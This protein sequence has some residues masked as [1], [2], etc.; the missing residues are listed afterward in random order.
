MPCA[1]PTPR[2][3]PLVAV[4]YPTHRSVPPFPLPA[5][6][7]TSNTRCTI[8]KVPRTP[9]AAGSCRLQLGFAKDTAP[10]HQRHLRP[11]STAPFTRQPAHR[12][13]CERRPTPDAYVGLTVHPSV[14]REH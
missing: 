6:H 5:A 1:R 11:P 14:A 8:L 9:P 12:A 4:C 7:R 3:P 2:H 10:P 13:P